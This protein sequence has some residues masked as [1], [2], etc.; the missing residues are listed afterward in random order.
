[1]VTGTELQPVENECRINAES[2]AKGF[3]PAPGEISA[4]QEPGGDWRS[5]VFRRF[6]RHEDFADV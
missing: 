5:C 6:G 1:M 4:Y 3:L 2:A